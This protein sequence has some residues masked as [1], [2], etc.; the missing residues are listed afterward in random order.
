MEAIA[1][2]VENEF[3]TGF[4][5]VE[6][7]M[8]TFYTEGTEVVAPVTKRN[9]KDLAMA[10]AMGLGTGLVIGAAAWFH[11]RNLRKALLKQFELSLVIAN[12]KYKR[13]N[14]I[15]EFGKKEIDLAEILIENP[16]SYV[17]V[18]IDN[19]NE[20]KF[21]TKKEKKRW[22]EVTDNITALT[23]NWYDRG[24]ENGTIGKDIPEEETMETLEEK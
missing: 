13:D 20:V 21:M 10:F 16:A 24:V 7:E 14:S 22:K 3:E 12:R 6:D 15:I 11:E 17:K 23:I 18:I 19:I 1:E 8:E 5:N 4:E 9:K 2:V